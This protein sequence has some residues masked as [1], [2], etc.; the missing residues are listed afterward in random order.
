MQ[1]A[2]AIKKILYAADAKES[3]LAEAQEYLSQTLEAGEGKAEEDWILTCN[4]A[5]AIKRWETYRA[6]CNEL[7]ASVDRKMQGM[8][9]LC[10]DSHTTWWK[11][12]VG[13]VSFSFPLFGE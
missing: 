9:L 7:R 6:R 8:F 13:F 4:G 1:V 11:H 3:A 12:C 2:V 5:L 10:S